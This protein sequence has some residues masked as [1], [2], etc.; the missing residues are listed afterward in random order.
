MPWPRLSDRY[1]TH[2]PCTCQYE[3]SSRCTRAEAGTKSSHNFYVN[4]DLNTRETPE[5]RERLIGKPPFN[6]LM[7][8]NANANVA[9]MRILRISSLFC[10]RCHRH[11]MRGVPL[12][13][14]PRALCLQQKVHVGACDRFAFTLPM[15]PI[16]LVTLHRQR[17]LFNVLS[18][19]KQP[20]LRKTLPSSSHLDCL[21]A[22]TT[23]ADTCF[24]LNTE[25]L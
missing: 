15:L 17:L 24:R 5:Q 20:Y 11:L 22:L 6:M 7:A 1:Q 8:T 14:R 13:C 25:I 12:F 19:P 9:R 21:L 3:D 23:L 10:L 16:P 2:E 18:M 4:I